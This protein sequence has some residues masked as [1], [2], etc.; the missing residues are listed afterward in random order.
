M[1][2]LRRKKQVTVYRIRAWRYFQKRKPMEVLDED[3]GMYVMVRL[4]YNY[5][6]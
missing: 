5:N 6:G 2:V 4:Q 1:H 3:P